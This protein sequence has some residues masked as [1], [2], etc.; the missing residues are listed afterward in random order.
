MIGELTAGF[1][2][3]T[4]DPLRALDRA[5]AAADRARNDHAILWRAATARADAGA[6][7]ARY[8]AGT[9]KGPLDGV[10]VAVKD[11]IDVAGLPTTSGTKFLTEPAV[12]DA[13]VVQRLR[14]AGAI[15]FAKTN[16]HE[17]GIQ[18]TGVNP[19]HGTPVNPWDPERIPGGSSSGSAVAVASGIAPIAV[20]TDAGG[21][22]RIPAAING[23]VGLKPTFG[24]VPL[25]GITRLTIDLD[26]AGPIAWTV[27]DATLLYEVLASRKVDRAAMVTSPA[28]L[29]DFF[30]GI[31]DGV[32]APVRQ[33]A[34]E[35]FGSLPEVASP[36]SALAAAVE[37]V[38]VGSDAQRTCGDHLRNHGHELAPDTRVILRLGAG[39]S[40]A[41]RRRADGVR[42]AMRREIDGLLAKH[43]VLIGPALGCPAPRIHRAARETGE[44]DTVRIARLA[45][46][47]F[48]ANL[49]GHPSVVVPC[50]REGL[51][52]AMQIIGRHH[53]EARV[54]AAARAIERNDGPRRPPRSYAQQL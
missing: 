49:T 18:P 5:L 30:R 14:A 11:C 32:G 1:R 23:L 25:D 21:S 2:A 28:L 37:F 40:A 45:A 54:L 31:V 41:D 19:H 39:L 35:A 33:A 52:V 48:V 51:P 22:I 4:D 9:P 47:S 34:R 44:L 53:D 27:E 36:F 50:V 3:G 29:M 20:G 12:A 38:I 13:A 24:A 43:D 17:L 7:T 8:R 15:V 42:A 10:A 26:H 16:M 6:A 46:Q